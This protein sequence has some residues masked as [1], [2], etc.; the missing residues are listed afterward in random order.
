MFRSEVS[1]RTTRARVGIDI[2]RNEARPVRPVSLLDIGPSHPKHL[3]AS[4]SSLWHRNLLVD[5][6]LPEVFD[7]SVAGPLH[8]ARVQPEFNGSPVRSPQYMGLA[9]SVVVMV[10][11]AQHSS[12]FQGSLAP[13]Y[14]SLAPFSMAC[15]R[16]DLAVMC[17]ISSAILPAL[18][19]TNTSY[20]S[21]VMRTFLQSPACSDSPSALGPLCVV[22]VR[23]RSSSS[24]LG[25]T[26]TL[27]KYF[28]VAS[29]FSQS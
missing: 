4:F 13:F 17:E 9:R 2:L 14:C 22:R 10:S 11:I 20:S 5:V 1:L 12:A 26:E 18:V 6:H 25:L 19:S 23:R 15:C 7:L 27:T 24:F 16:V 3:M 28:P 29:C 8:C 21:G